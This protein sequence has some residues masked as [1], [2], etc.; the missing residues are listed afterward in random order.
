HDTFAF[1]NQ[2]RWESFYGTS[3]H[4]TTRDREPPPSYSLHC[5]VLAASTKQ[6]FFNARFDPQKPRADER[7]YRRLIRRVVSTNPRKSLPDSNKI[8]IPGYATLREFS[9]AQERRLKAECGGA[10]Q[11]YFKRGHW[12]IVFP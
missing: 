4:W 10:W 1:P 8:E 3:G 12:R 6:F 9:Q 5:F 7:K 11:S 2:L